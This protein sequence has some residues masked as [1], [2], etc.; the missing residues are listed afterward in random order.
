MNLVY[1][2]GITTCSIFLLVLDIEK[3]PVV[4]KHLVNGI[5]S[6]M[7]CELPLVYPCSQLL[8]PYVVSESF[9]V[10]G[11]SKEFSGATIVYAMDG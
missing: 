4:S 11:S 7:E 3:Q 8:G 10:T 5:K 1:K 2:T 9:Q 6:H